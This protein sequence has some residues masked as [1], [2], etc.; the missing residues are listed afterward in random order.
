MSSLLE[1]A[2]ANL[3]KELD[4]AEAEIIKRWTAVY[5]KQTLLKAIKGRK[6]HG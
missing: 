5:K 6:E 1:Q 3:D 2:K 4:A